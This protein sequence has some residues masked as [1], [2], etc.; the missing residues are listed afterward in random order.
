MWRATIVLLLLAALSGAPSRTSAGGNALADPTVTPASGSTLTVFSFSVRYDGTFPATTVTAAVAGLDLVMALA[1]G[2]MSA[3]TWV[4]SSTLP[5]GAWATTFIAYAEQGNV[6]TV[7]GPTLTVAPA[8]AVTPAPAPPGAPGPS[9]PERHTETSREPVTETVPTSTP[10]SA[11]AQPMPS[12]DVEPPVAAPS[13]P[14]ATVPA[15]VAMPVTPAAGPSSVGGL[16]V[17]AR[18]VPS[19]GPSAIAARSGTASAQARGLTPPTSDETVDAAG[20]GNPID[21]GT[22]IIVLIGILGVG[23]VALIGTATLIAR[24]RR[25]DDDEEPVAATAA[26]AL[27]RRSVRRARQRMGED[28]IMAAMGIGAQDQRKDRRRP[29]PIDEDQA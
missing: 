21:E 10:V 27:Q 11:P 26:A 29:P 6:A 5:A 1:D 4:A 2:S 14:D 23:A 19:I 12:S 8:D 18:S 20:A 22:S 3:G 13:T 25:A 16:G 24:R 15:A 17:S 7:T 9:G 28:P